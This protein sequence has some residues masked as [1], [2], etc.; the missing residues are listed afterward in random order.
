MDER[1]ISDTPPSVGGL[2]SDTFGAF[3]SR[4]VQIMAIS[5]VPVAPVVVLGGAGLLWGIRSGVVD[6]EDPGLGV[7]AV[8]GALFV[9]AL[10]LTQVS[11]AALT[12]AVFRMARNEDVDIG[13]CLRVGLRR[14]PMV[15]LVGLVSGLLSGLGTMFCIVPGIILGVM[16][17]VAIPVTVVEN[18][19]VGLSLSRSRDLVRG[20]GWTVFGALFVIGL[21]QYAINMALQLL[22]RPLPVVGVI[23]LGIAY[24]LET[25]LQATLSAVLYYRLRSSTEA[26]DVDQ[27][28]AVFD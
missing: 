11:T 22:L 9:L 19:G 27:V 2:L 20:F 13:S 17:S 18:T 15:L 7:I 4:F 5:T 14:L 1:L 8:F 26:I 24:I 3:T 23:L 16:L 25:A 6:M 10:L 21:I 28:A 12:C